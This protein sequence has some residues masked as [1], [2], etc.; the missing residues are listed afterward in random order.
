M[1]TLFALSALSLSPNA[2]ASETVTSDGSRVNFEVNVDQKDHVE[3]DLPGNIKFLADDRLNVDE[4]VND[5]FAFATDIRFTAPV[6][7]NAF[8]FAEE[9]RVDD[10]PLGGDLFGFAETLQ[11][12]GDVQGDVYAFIGDLYVG[13]DAV[14]HGNLTAFGGTVEIE[15]TVLGDAQLQT[16]VFELS[17]HIIGD[18]DL[19]TGDFIH[20]DDARIGGDFA[21]TMSS[22]RDFDDLVGGEVE[23]VEE[24]DDGVEIE[25]EKDDE[26]SLVFAAIKL[27]FKYFSGMLV[28]SLLLAIGGAPIRKALKALR[29]RPVSAAAGGFVGV[30]V[31]PVASM[32]VMFTLVGAPLGAIGMALWVVG[33]YIARLFAA[34]ALG[35]AL[36]TR[37]RPGAIG[38]PYVSLAVGLAILLPL[39]MLPWLGWLTWFAATIAGFGVMWTAACALRE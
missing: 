27:V 19:T 24:S 31:L 23:F 15:G 21:Y 22:A 7:D 20:T 5:L 33:L 30:T 12:N 34:Q 14:V 35:E 36:L 13:P 1:F 26:G 37:I 25:I 10:V 3:F 9:I 39:F 8:V 4:P 18:V 11:L 38:N 6:E 16:G 28:G 32:A 29:D 17:G 2:L